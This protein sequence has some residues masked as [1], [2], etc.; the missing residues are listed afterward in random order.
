M[1]RYALT[2]LFCVCAS[3]FL[4]AQ[5][6][7]SVASDAP[8]IKFDSTTYYFDTVYQSSTVD[9]EFRFTNKGKTPLII[10]NATGS[11]GSIVPSYT[12]EPIAPGQTGIIHVVFNTTGRLGPQ[13][14]CV[15]VTSNA[16]EPTIVLHIKGIVALPPPDPNGPKIQFDTMAFD[17]DTI[18]QGAII[19]QKFRFR[20]IGKQP[21]VISSVVNG[22]GG[23]YPDY[24]PKEPVAPGQTGVI[25]MKFNSVG[26]LGHQGKAIFVDSNAINGQV[27]LRWS[28][29]VIASKAMVADSISVPLKR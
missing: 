15:T 14:K 3:F 17:Y 8:I 4:N 5:K 1:T 21:L 16:S 19:Y 24:Y 6:A 11:S 12:K 20:N 22:D 27:I 7:G 10:S 23:M 13:D 18:M 25:R 29:T 26:K 9:H 28:G 2:F